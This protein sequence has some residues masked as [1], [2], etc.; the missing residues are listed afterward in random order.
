MS[1]QYPA[2][3]RELSHEAIHE[4]PRQRA[5]IAAA[6][7]A[8]PVDEESLRRGVWTYVRGERDRSTSPGSVVVAVTELVNASSKIRTA[9]LRQSMMRRVNRWC[10]Q[11]YFGHLGNEAVAAGVGALSVAS[12]AAPPTIVSKR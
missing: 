5:V 1:R 7:A 4:A 9:F 11:A 8:T 6:L 10:V 2:Q 3:S 12:V